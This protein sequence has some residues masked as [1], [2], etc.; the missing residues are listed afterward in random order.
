VVEEANSYGTVKTEQLKI[1]DNNKIF[2][3]EFFLIRA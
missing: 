3:P 2:I 1:V